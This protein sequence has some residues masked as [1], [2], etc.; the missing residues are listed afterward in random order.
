MLDVEY[1]SYHDEA[2]SNLPT[3]FPANRETLNGSAQES[4]ESRY[5]SLVSIG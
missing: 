1:G 5:A 2:A 4:A 3:H